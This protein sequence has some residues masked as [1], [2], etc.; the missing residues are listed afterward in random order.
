[1]LALPFVIYCLINLCNKEY[2]LDSSNYGEALTRIQ[3]ISVDELWDIDAAKVFVGWF[4]FQVFLERVLPGDVAEGVQLKDGQR[5]KYRLNGHLAFWISIFFVEWRALPWLTGEKYPLAYVHTKYVQLAT[6]S[7]V[8]STVLSVYLYVSS[9]AAEKRGELLAAGGNTG[10]S[11]Y[12]FFIGRQLNPRIGSFDLKC[13]CELRPG[14]IGWAVIN[15]GMLQKYQQDNNGKLMPELV[16]LNVFQGLY[17]WDALYQERAILTTMD[18]TTDGFGYM[19]AFGDLSWVPFTYTLQARYLVDHADSASLPNWVLVVICVL[20]CMGYAAF[21][22]SNG[23]KDQFRRDPTHPSVAHLQ[24]I[25]TKTGRKL[26]VSGWW[27]LA[28]KINYVADWTMGLSWCSLCGFN[29]IIPFFY[30]IYFFVLLVHRAARDHHMCKIK[31]GDDWDRY[32]QKVPYVFFPGV[33]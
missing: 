15:L 21:R 26:L 29:H 14:L 19:L 32:C 31:Y 22:G 6:A 25:E 2:C 20:K 3:N 9:F 12:D 10:W 28:R 18:I 24:T 8:F 1:M 27:G 11:V 17:V 23:E 7:L 5:L 30:S 13:F 16:I 4:A 33:I